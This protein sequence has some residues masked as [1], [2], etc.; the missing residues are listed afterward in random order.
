MENPL[1]IKSGNLSS[2]RRD[3]LKKSGSLTVMSMFGIGFF[4]AC[5]SDDDA[6]PGPGGSVNDPPAGS[7]SGIIVDGKITSVDL[8]KNT[9]LKATGGWLLIT[10]SQLLIVNLGSDSFNALTSICTHSQCDRNWSFA[11]N[12]FICSCHGSRFGTDGSV[13]TGPAT[14]PLKNYPIEKKDNILTITKD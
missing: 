4:T 7:G 3:F 8:D 2:Q 13:V 14:Q 5:T 11:S 6:M 9:V 10:D 1:K 12:V